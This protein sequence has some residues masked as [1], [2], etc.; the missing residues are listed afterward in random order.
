MPKRSVKILLH[1][2]VTDSVDVEKN[3]STR[4]GLIKF[5]YG[6]LNGLASA[7]YAVGLA[8]WNLI[9]LPL[10][11]YR[12]FFGAAP[13]RPQVK[14]VM[15]FMVLIIVVIAP[16]FSFS[17]L[18]EG[19]QLS[20]NVLGTSDDA[21][22]DISA[23]QDA[24]ANQDYTKAQKDFSNAL[25]KLESLQDDLSKS[26]ALI[27]AASNFAPASIN[28]QNLLE[29]A[30][31]LTESGLTAS[32]LLGQL[33][34]LSFTA[35]GLSTSGEQTSE[36]AIKQLAEDSK[37]INEKLS[38]AASLLAPINTSLLPAEYQLALNETKAVVAEVS[39]QTAQ[40]QDMSELLSQMM[41]GSKKFLVLLQNNNELRA[42]GGFV[43]TIAQGQ[44][45][46]G[47]ISKLDIRTVYDPD[48]QIL[49][50]VK[51]PSPLQA[52]N[53]RLFLRDKIG[54]AHV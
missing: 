21:M 29:A 3:R 22:R 18:S 53:S 47:V 15:V 11:M 23:A 41:L 19:W 27:Q 8:V 12:T 36:A 52:V 32:Q 7:S 51:P 48:G 1:H 4:S 13:N 50:W 40:L 5:W 28:S 54:R 49:D 33:N 42:T 20:G 9:T 35:E 45:E 25:T 34:S 26:S 2:E 6:L 16:F 10:T 44:I 24:I 30:T 17:L 46:N 43:G 39:A 14:P 31:L 38:R 37:I